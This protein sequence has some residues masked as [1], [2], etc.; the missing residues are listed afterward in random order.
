MQTYGSKLKLQFLE[1]TTL[2]V[3]E[4]MRV[5][6]GVDLPGAFEATFSR[7]FKIARQQAVILF[8]REVFREPPDFSHLVRGVVI[9]CIVAFRSGGAG[10]VAHRIV[11][12]EPKGG[13]K[14][15][16]KVLGLD[17]KL[18]YKGHGTVSKDKL[19]ADIHITL[20]GVPI[21]V[22]MQ[23]EL[24]AAGGIHL[25]RGGLALRKRAQQPSA[26]IGLE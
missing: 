5:L 10:Y 2:S 24:T 18:H 23:G 6:Q 1:R 17:G 13:D 21:E 8:N 9:L 3:G 14:V 12:L 19:H 15:F 7:Q 22:R 4:T 16:L 26:S 20:P 25:K 11:L